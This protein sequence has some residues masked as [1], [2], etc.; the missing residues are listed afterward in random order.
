MLVI[1]LGGPARVGK[2]TLAK[3]ISEYA[4]NNGYTP[5]ILPF[6]AMLKEEA[7]RRGYSKERNPESYRTFCQTLGSDMRKQDPDHWVRC[8]R[9]RVK[10]LYEDE[11]TALRDDPDT[12]H[13]KVIIVD[14][15]RYPNEVAA[16]RDLRAL[17]IFISAGSRELIDHHAEWRKH[18]SEEMANM[19]E[20]GHKDYLDMFHYTIKNDSTERNFK[21]KCGDR[22]DEWFHITA[23]SLI[24]N[25]CDCELCMSVRQDRD[26]DADTVI[27][28]IMD[29]ITNPNEEKNGKAKRKTKPSD[30]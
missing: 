10:K 14:D 2:T 24:E 13:E 17:T 5:V 8:F 26:P 12:W 27:K 7:E 3:W 9:E 15:C 19:I 23:E 18:E 28:E 29:M 21:E 6:A 20:S 1:M 16:A 4:Y 25:L 30:S 11:Q 22:Y